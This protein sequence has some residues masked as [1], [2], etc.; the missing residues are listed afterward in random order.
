[1][2]KIASATVSAAI[3]FCIVIL[4]GLAFQVGRSGV[5]QESKTL[6]GD[7]TVLHP[8]SETVRIGN[9]KYIVELEWAGD[10]CRA[11]DTY[12][13]TR[14]WRLTC[15][16]ENIDTWFLERHGKVNTF[17][18]E[19]LTIVQSEDGVELFTIPVNAPFALYPDVIKDRSIND[20]L[21]SVAREKAFR[22]HRKD[23]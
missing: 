5:T 22:V 15:P 18:R 11:V 9:K 23:K 6:N 3:V 10:E 21:A 8:T 13:V 20:N 12:L 14:R 16:V 1:M 17:R 7:V 4:L 19:H 2:K